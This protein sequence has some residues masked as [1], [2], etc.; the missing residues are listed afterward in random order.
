MANTQDKRPFDKGYYDGYH[1]LEQGGSY[2]G[3]DQSAYSRGHSQ[4]R[5]ERNH[6]TNKE[7]VK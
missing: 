4:G 2:I 3:D 7:K 1:G 5:M 6:T